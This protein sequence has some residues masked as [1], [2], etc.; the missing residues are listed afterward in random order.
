[1][2]KILLIS[3]ISILLCSCY[4]EENRKFPSQALE[5]QYKEHDYIAFKFFEQ[6]NCVGFV[7]NPDCKKC[8]KNERSNK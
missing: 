4:H 8:N 3:L 7:H 5:F 2:K 1:M 6:S